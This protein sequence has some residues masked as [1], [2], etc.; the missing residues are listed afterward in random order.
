MANPFPSPQ[1]SVASAAAAASFTASTWRS[2]CH[3][4]A[5]AAPQHLPLM[6]QLGEVATSEPALPGGG[7]G[8]KGGGSKVL[9]WKLNL[10]MKNPR[11]CP[12]EPFFE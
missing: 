10:A 1:T 4:M 9:M 7:C 8:V 5:R 3:V 6:E 2:G 12:V 11:D